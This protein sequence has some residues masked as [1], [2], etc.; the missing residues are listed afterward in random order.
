[1]GECLINMF[2]RHFRLIKRSRWVVKHVFQLVTPIRLLGKGFDAPN[3]NTRC[4]LWLQW[5]RQLNLS[6][7]FTG[8]LIRAPSVPKSARTRTANQE[9]QTHFPNK[10]FLQQT[11]KGKGK[12]D[13]YKRM[14]FTP[15]LAFFSQSSNCYSRHFCDILNLKPLRIT[16]SKYKG[17]CEIT[18]SRDFW[19]S[20]KM[21]FDNSTT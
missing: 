1:M 20:I 3:N 15:S 14:I 6:F 16:L 7:D 4:K 8:C 19:Y 21:I 12:W 13:N 17:C 11:T 10:H 5:L 18:L 9:L 2:L